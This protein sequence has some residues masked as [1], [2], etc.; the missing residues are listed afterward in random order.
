MRFVRR[1]LLSIVALLVLGAVLVWTA[2]AELAYRVLRDRIAVL[3][4]DGISG[5][6]WHGAAQRASSFGR[7]LGTLE[8]RVAKAPLLSRRYAA[9]L[10]LAGER[11]HGAASIAGGADDLTLRDL[12]FVLPAELLGP[13]LDI[14]ALQFLGAVRLDVQEATVRGGLL[15]SATGSAEWT[16]LGIRGAAVATLPGL[17]AEFAPT[18]PGTIDATLRDLGG[19]LAVAGTVRI[20][21]GRFVSETSLSLRE[22]NPQ[23]EELLKF[24]GQRT[25]DGGSY[26]RIEGTLK[27]LW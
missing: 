17:R 24:I 15:E 23:L 4:L 21:G 1:L 9:D 18:A 12:D 11:L 6:V 5:S 2:P 10:E 25:P 19:P 22:P 26:L 13:A 7:A 14:P 27:P 16:E 20:A 3:E 8:W